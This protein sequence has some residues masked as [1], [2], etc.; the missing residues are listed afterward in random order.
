M[1]IALGLSAALFALSA[2]ASLA[3]EPAMEM[4]SSMGKILVDEKQMTLYT[5]DKDETNKSNCYDQC[6]V[7]WPP[8]MAA[9]DAMAEGEWTIVERT[10]G[11]KQWAYEGKPLYLWIQDKAPGDMTGEGKGNG[12]WHVAKAS[13]M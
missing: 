3:A 6:A 5:F 4:D 13:A 2:S 8:L 12:A 11:S 9:A 1:R 7:N 10:D